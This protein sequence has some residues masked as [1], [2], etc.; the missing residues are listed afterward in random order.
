[1]NYYV[2]LN[3]KNKP[4]VLYRGTPDMEEQVWQGDKWGP[5]EFLL[6]CLEGHG[7]IYFIEEAQAKKHFPAEAFA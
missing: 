1:M 5:G 3:D 2:R 7:N 6:D 4:V